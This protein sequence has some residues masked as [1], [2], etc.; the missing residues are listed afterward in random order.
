M[1]DSEYTILQHWILQARDEHERANQWRA[2]ALVLAV[3]VIAVAL[4]MGAR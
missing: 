4:V 3:L 1:T 2:A